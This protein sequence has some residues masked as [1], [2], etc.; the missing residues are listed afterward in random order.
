VGTRLVTTVT[1]SDN[2]RVTAV[3]VRY[4]GRVDLRGV[5]ILPSTFE[6]RGPTAPRTVT[7]FTSATYRRN[8]SSNSTLATPTPELPALIRYRS[9]G[10]TPSARSQT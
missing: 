4:A 5:D 6:V 9:T 1:A 8:W 7:P 3:V 2:W 10:R